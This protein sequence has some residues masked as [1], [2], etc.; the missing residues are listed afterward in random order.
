[1]EKETIAGAL[2]ALRSFPFNHRAM[3]TCLVY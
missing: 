2:Q 3:S 1:M